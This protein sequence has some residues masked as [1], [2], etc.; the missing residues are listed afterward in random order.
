MTRASCNQACVACRA[1]HSCTCPQQRHIG[2]SAQALAL[3]VLLKAWDQA[4]VICMH[5][6]DTC[7]GA[8]RPACLIA[9]V[10]SHEC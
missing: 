10:Q 2:G 3:K 1:D 4:L 7:H 6:C 9:S 8:V 5:T